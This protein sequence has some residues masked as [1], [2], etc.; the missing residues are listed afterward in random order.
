MGGGRPIAH[1]DPGFEADKKFSH[2]KEFFMPEKRGG[3]RGDQPIAYRIQARK[4]R[5]GTSGEAPKGTD[6]AD[7][8]ILRMLRLGSPT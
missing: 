7:A 1:G 6:D 2:P 4:K 3:W 8:L 5:V